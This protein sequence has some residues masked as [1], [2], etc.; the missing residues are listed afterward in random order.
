MNG[1]AWRH[2][3][4]V[5]FMAGLAAPAGM[6]LVGAVLRWLLSGEPLLVE[7]RWPFRGGAAV[8]WGVLGMACSLAVTAGL[9]AVWPAFA[10]SMERTGLKVGEEVLNVAGFPV[11]VA[12][13][14]L[15]ALGEEALFRGGLQPRLGVAA[16]AVAFGLAHGAWNLRA[17]WS[18]VLAAMLAGLVFGLVYTY[19]GLLWSAILAHAGHN[20]LVT[21]Y[22][23]HRRRRRK[24]ESS[25]D[26]TE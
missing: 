6:V 11:M 26:V 17:L 10:R 1:L 24:A 8:F 19:S 15:A 13:V 5:F 21:I 23:L 16:A 20:V 7:L 9:A 3:L 25:T 12:V 18:Y 14:A 2:R 4:G 22:L